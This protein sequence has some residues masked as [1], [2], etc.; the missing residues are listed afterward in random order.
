[1]DKQF[2]LWL[3]PVQNKQALPMLQ[4]QVSGSSY[5]ISILA[6]HSLTKNCQVLETVIQWLVSLEQS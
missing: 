5:I 4:L 2:C 6:L 1:M 3:I